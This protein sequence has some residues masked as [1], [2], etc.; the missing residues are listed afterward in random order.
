VRPAPSQ[1][2]DVGRPVVL[3]ADAGLLD[4]LLRLA[5]AA[6]VEPFVASDVAAAQPAWQEAP[7]VVVGSDQAAALARAA[8]G[9]RPGV[10]VATRAGTTE[11]FQVAVE[12]GAERVAVL[13]E[14]ESWLVDAF[15][16]AAEQVVPGALVAVIGGRG[17]AG[18]TTLAAALAV[19]ALRADV[20]TMVVDADPLGGG[21]D[22]VL[23]GE[24]ADGLRWAQLAGA[25]GRIGA[26]ALR[27]ALP[28]IDELTVLTFGRGPVE[29]VT[30]DAM[31]ALLE[32][33][34]RGND[35]VV[36]DLPRRVDDVA[37][38]ALGKADVTLLVL[39]AEVRA[40]VAASRV[41]RLVSAYCAD[42]RLVARGPSPSGLSAADLAEALAM[43]LAGELRPEPGL[44]GDLER[45]EPP[46]RRG[47]GPLAA[48]C[49]EFLGELL[50]GSLAAGDRR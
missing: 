34:L 48:F 45:G 15:A 14:A 43:P 12:I 6:G 32:A 24:D 39:P 16:D 50:G 2:I 36:V 25:R 31:T 28:R 35:L 30:P 21:I 38:V 4:D 7:L 3:T 23:G 33:G 11:V 8:P 49:R 19:T 5:A 27:D 1:P 13:P 10:V 42:V 44:A 26:A 20:R 37:R 17:G 40:A 47:K 46:A 29:P 9:R 41:A 18:A 22:L